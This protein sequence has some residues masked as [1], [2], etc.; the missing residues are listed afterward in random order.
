MAYRIRKVNQGYIRSQKEGE[1]RIYRVIY[2]VS[3]LTTINYCAEN[4]NK[5]VGRQIS[6][7]TVT[8]QHTILHMYKTLCKIM[9]IMCGKKKRYRVSI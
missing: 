4:A 8:A 9:Q 3:V 7:Y 2:G 1:Y 5:N 6:L